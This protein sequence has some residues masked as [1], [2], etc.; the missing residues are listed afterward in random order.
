MKPFFEKHLH[1]LTW[2][3]NVHLPGSPMYT[4]FL[5]NLGLLIFLTENWN[6]AYSRYEEIAWMTLHFHRG[7]KSAESCVCLKMF[8]NLSLLRTQEISHILGYHLSWGQDKAIIKSSPLI[9]L[10]LTGMHMPVFHCMRL[11]LFFLFVHVEL[12][13]NTW[14]LWAAVL[15]SNNSFLRSMKNEA[16]L[17]PEVLEDVL[18]Q[19]ILTAWNDVL[20]AKSQS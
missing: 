6:I 17:W 14:Y 18:Q 15:G 8:E 9:V 11:E 4:L 5:W 19:Y 1:I 16:G 20:P 3:Y 7:V 13:L 12:S 2:F 10:C